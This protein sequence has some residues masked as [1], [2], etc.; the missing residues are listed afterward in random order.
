[1][2]GNKGAWFLG[3]T[4]VQMCRQDKGSYKYFL[5]HAV[6]KMWGRHG[7]EHYLSTKGGGGGAIHS[8][9][10]PRKQNGILTATCCLSTC[11]MVL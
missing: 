10:N 1:M 3:A 11:G 4:Q 6:A 9:Q 5:R 2:N 7:A 8:W